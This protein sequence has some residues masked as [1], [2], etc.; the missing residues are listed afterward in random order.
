MKRV[1]MIDG[2]GMDHV[3]GDYD[4]VLQYC[5]RSMEERGLTV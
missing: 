4:G 2:I 5:A 1:K 3:G